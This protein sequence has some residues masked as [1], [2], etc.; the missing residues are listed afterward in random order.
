MKYPYLLLIPLLSIS[1]CTNTVK[2]LTSRY[3]YFDTLETITIYDGL[4]DNMQKIE[5]ILKTVHEESDNYSTDN[6]LYKINTNS[7]RVALSETLLG[8]INQ[9]SQLYGITNGYFN[10]LVGSLSKKW[11]ESL[12]DK[13]VLSQT[14]ISE[15]LEKINNTELLFYYNDNIEIEVTKVGEAE[16]DFGG[17]AKGFA[18]D[19]IKVYLEEANINSYL[20]DCG[21]S[22]ILL[23]EKPTRNGN[24]NVGLNIPGVNNAYVQLKNCFIGASGTSEQGVEID[25]VTYSHIVNPF[26]GSVINEYDYTFVAGESGSL[27]DAFATAFMLMPLDMI[28]EYVEEYD[29]SVIIYKDSNLI[30]K[31]DDIEIKYHS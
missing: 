4:K 29:L 27:C 22:S 31:T 5:E 6:D 14:I 7:G 10:P 16:L 18:L 23:G 2:T 15:E 8:L 26:T 9:S 11:K 21:F 19:Q 12:K 13:Q 17:I 25:G 28:K 20:I 24:F 3:T 1:S 30:Y